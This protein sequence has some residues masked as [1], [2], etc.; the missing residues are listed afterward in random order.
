MVVLLVVV[1]IC[2]SPSDPVRQ[3]NEGL[4]LLE[5]DNV[6]WNDIFS[7]TPKSKTLDSAIVCFSNAAVMAK[8]ASYPRFM[9]AFCYA[10]AGDAVA[11]CKILKDQPIS[12]AN[13]EVAALL[14]RAYEQSGLFHRASECYA[15]MFLAEP[16]AL[17]SSF[18]IAM[19]QR[20]SL[21]ADS[22]VKKTLKLSAQRFSESDDPV[23]ESKWAALQFWSGNY[24]EALPLLLRVSTRMPNYSRPHYYLGRLAEV[25][26][27]F[28]MAESEYR[29][30]SVLGIADTLP[31]LALSR[32]WPKKYTYEPVYGYV[33]TASYLRTAYHTKVYKG[34]VLQGKPF[35][36]LEEND[37]RTASR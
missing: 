27:D 20:D 28:S 25:A 2:P 6:G 29:K 23:L 14:G 18:F 8:G 16:A 24:Q 5:R 37:D 31:S 1:C 21:L 11:V 22:A 17:R 36:E 4:R 32:L 30:A 33:R 15:E 12:D 9:E 34:G 26:G 3:V 7:G 13:P 19:Y 10:V 35:F